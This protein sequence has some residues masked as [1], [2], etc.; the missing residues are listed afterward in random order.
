MYGIGAVL[1]FLLTQVPDG[2]P[3]LFISEGEIMET[4]LRG[5][6]KH[7]IIASLVVL[8]IYSL[9]MFLVFELCV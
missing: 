1:N 9:A 7:I 8:C 3:A 4:F 2:A 6:D 5:I